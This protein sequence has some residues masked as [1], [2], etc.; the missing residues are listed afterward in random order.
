MSRLIARREGFALTTTIVALVVVGLVVTGGFFAAS[1][2]GKISTSARDAD[3]ALQAAENGINTVVG[4]WTVG[5]LAT[6]EASG[7]RNIPLEVGGRIIGRATVEGRRLA[8]RLFFITSTGRVVH[9]NRDGDAERRLGMLVR[10]STMEVRNDRA[11]SAYA[12][13]EVGGNSKVSGVD[14][15]NPHWDEER[16]PQPAG[17]KVGI[18]ARD[19][20]LVTERGSGTIEGDPPKRENETITRDSLTTFGEWDYEEL[21]ARADKVFPGGTGLG[22]EIAP[23]VADDGSCNEGAPFNWGAPGNPNSPCH[24]YFPIIHVQGDLDL[25]GQG[26]GQGILLVDGNLGIRGGFEFSGII[27]VRGKI[28]TGGGNSKIYGTITVLGENTSEKS[29]IKDCDT[30]GCQ[31]EVTGNPIV[32]LS[33]CAIKRAVEYNKGTSR[34]RPVAERSWVDLTGAGVG[35]D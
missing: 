19:T 33:T 15:R 32:H 17:T 20:S 11:M 25:N 18:V 30:E 6:T 5:E 2:E 16:C 8:D 10:T 3:I 31:S 34:V 9:G 26:Q 27:I 35:V 4:K 29:K 24:F 28:E 23:V 1:Q 22:A 14:T 7:P 12:A 21:A 13:V